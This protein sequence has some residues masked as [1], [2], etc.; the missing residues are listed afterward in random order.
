MRVKRDQ[1]S[2]HGT[3]VRMSVAGLLAGAV[4]LLFRSFAPGGTATTTTA[5]R[6]VISLASGLL[7]VA[8]LAPL[9]LRLTMG[10][11]LRLGAV[12]LTLY[13]TGTLT[14]LLEAYFYTTVLTPF[15][16]AAALVFLALQALVI[17]LL[18]VLV[19][20]PSGVASDPHRRPGLAETGHRPL[21]NWTWRVLLA[22]VL[23]V[24][25]YYAFAATVTPIEHEFYY[26]PT[27]IAQ[28]HTTVPPTEVTIAL[29][30]VRGLL[31]VL[32]LLPALS[33]VPQQRWVSVVYLGLIGAV[34]EGWVPLLGQTTWPLAM[35]LGNF[36][37][38]TGDAFGR[39]FVVMVL[40]GTLGAGWLPRVRRAHQQ[41]LGRS[42]R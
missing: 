2:A 18:V 34:V 10:L 13:V 22:G 23:Y 24:P 8:I 33:V 15:S 40:L 5:S 31:F 16:L 7:Y 39:A 32:A 29:E 36:V 20:R 41:S 11:W 35:R 38:L 19:V 30:A 4:L 9:A 17:A 3:W 21:A 37:E 1:Q 26:D 12:F 27:F 42:G 28:L 14:D 25:I 6:V